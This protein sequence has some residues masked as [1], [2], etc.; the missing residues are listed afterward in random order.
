MLCALS[1]GFSGGFLFCFF[2]SS[3]VE[4]GSIPDRNGRL[5]SAQS[6]WGMSGVLGVGL[7]LAVGG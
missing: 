1:R 2:G 4:A 3:L 6:V 7:V 5:S